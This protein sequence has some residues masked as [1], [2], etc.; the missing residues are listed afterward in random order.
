M[1]KG[2]D[3]PLVERLDLLQSRCEELALWRRAF[4]DPD[5]DQNLA[6]QCEYPGSVVQS[7][8][9]SRLAV[10]LWKICAWRDAA[11]SGTPR[12]KMAGI[13]W[14]N[15]GHVNQSGFAHSLFIVELSREI[16]RG[17]FVAQTNRSSEQ[18]G[19]RFVRYWNRLPLSN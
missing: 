16:A 5:P 19:H 8:D 10:R 11:G 13:A 18:D 2:R 9:S 15:L 14:L 4:I 17:V 3:D 12:E 7:G 1:R 6:Q